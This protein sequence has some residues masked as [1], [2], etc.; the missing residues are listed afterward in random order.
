MADVT[1]KHADTDGAGEAIVH[2]A[3]HDPF[4]YLGM[5]RDDDGLIVRAFLPSAHAVAV[6]HAVSGADVAKF[7]RIHRDGLFAARVKS[8]SPFPYRLRVE[9]GSGAELID[10]P[11][12]FPPVLGPL[13][14]H[15]IAEGNHFELYRKLGAHEVTIEGVAGVVFAVWAPNARRVSVVGPFNEWDGRRHPLRCHY[16]AGI[17]EIFLPGLGAGTLYKFE[18]K[19][20]SGEVLPL[21]ADPVALRAEH[22]PSTASIVDRL[23]SGPPDPT[24][25]E[26]RERKNAR[27]AAMSVFE[28]HLGSWRRSGDGRVLTYA[29]LG[30]ELIPYV[31]DMGFTHVELMPVM[32][33]PFDG[34]WGYQPLGLFAPTSRHGTPEDFRAFIRACHDADIAV[35]LDWV[36]AHFPEDAHGLAFFDGTHLYEHADERLGRHQDWGSLIYN[37]GRPE[38]ANFLIANALYWFDQFDVDGLRVDAVASMLYRDYSRAAGEWLPNKYGG[39]ENLEAIE[40]LRRLNHAVLTR[41]PGAIM[42]A[43]ESTA[44]PMVT[45]PPDIGGLGFSYKWNLGWMNDTLRY[46]ARDGVHRKFHQNELTFGLLYAFHENFI[47]P[48]SHDEVVHGKGSILAKMSGDSWQKFANLR[49]YYAFMFTQPGK[50]NLFM[51]DEFAQGAEWMHDRAL[52]WHLLDF[53]QHRGVQS[54]VRALN[55]LYRTRPELHE[56]DCEGDG[57]AWIDCSDANASVLSYLRRGRDPETFVVVVCNFTAVPRSSYRVGVPAA[58]LYREVLN[59]DSAYYGGS[60]VGNLGALATDEIAAHGYGHSLS[61]TLP[62]LATLVLAPQREPD[63]S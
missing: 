48:L 14:L 51:G 61:L 38:V 3:H 60:N 18:I 41:F 32:E 59:T 40:F 33:Y 11:Y 55:R 19:A 39:R 24:W 42:V 43:E 4:G 20:P 34:S 54:L 21:K 16:G 28:V 57:F 62:P 49:A 6:V 7:E 5:H 9:T 23:A 12:R 2:A 31:K 1:T 58:G 46:M 25:A 50:K 22:P 47:L 36:P 53:A 29:E 17:W 37:L 26:R 30:R 63:Q 15:L 13:D 44:W 10:D 45:R 27:D 8:T 52:D 35:I 56:R